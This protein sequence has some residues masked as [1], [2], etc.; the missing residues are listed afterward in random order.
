MVEY[1][2]AYV[3]VSIELVDDVSEKRRLWEGWA[4]DPSAFFETPENEAYVLLRCTPTSATVVTLGE[5]GPHRHRWK[6]AR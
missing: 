2:E 1:L 4:Y 6:P 3:D 5:A